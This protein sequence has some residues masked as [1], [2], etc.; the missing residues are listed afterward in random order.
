MIRPQKM[1]K[2]IEIL[3]I[4]LR[5]SSIYGKITE[6]AEFLWLIPV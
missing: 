6:K 5:F 4:N 2:L 1:N 3:Y